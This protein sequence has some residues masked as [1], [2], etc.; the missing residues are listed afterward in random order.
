[1]QQAQTKVIPFSHSKWKKELRQWLDPK[2]KKKGMLLPQGLEFNHLDPK[3]MSTPPNFVGIDTETFAENGNM[4]CLSNSKNNDTLYGSVDKLP[5][6]FDV[7]RYLKRLKT[8]K[9]TYFVA[10][11]LKFDASV[12]LKCMDKSILTK[13][14]YGIEDEKY[15]I[16]INDLTITY[17]HKKCL[18]FQ[19]KTNVVKIYDAMQFFMGAG[20]GGKSSLDAVAKVYL[21]EQKQ[22][23]GKY[24]DKKFPSK[25]T[26]KELEEIVEYCQLDCT[27]TEKLM[28]IWVDAF[29]KNF[30]FYP[31]AFYSAGYLTSQLFKTKLKSFPSFRKIPFPVQSLAYECYFGGRFEIMERG[32]LSNI[33][34]YDINSAYPYAMTLLPDFDNGKW[35]KITSMEKFQKY[36]KY[37]GFYRIQVKSNERNVS[38]FLFRGFNGQ[39]YAPRG[40]FI[41]FTTSFEIV[42]S[43]NYDVEIKEIIGYAFIPK[44]KVKTKFNRLIESMYEARL[45]Q[46]NPGQK[47]VYKVL[48]NSGYGKFAQNKPAPKNLFNP[49]YCAAITGKCRS[50]LLDAAKD[51]KEDIVMFATDGVFSKKKLKLP[52][53]KKKVL[54]AWDYEFHPDMLLVMAG[55]YSVNNK[56]NKKLKTKSRGFSLRHFDP[57]T[58]KEMHFDLGDYKLMLDNGKYFYEIYNM[59][60]VAISQAV[61]QHKYSKDD[62]GKM[63]YVRKEIDLNGDH[64]R[65]WN[66]ELVDVYGHNTS[67]T[68]II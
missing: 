6:I 11:N 63:E 16:K 50:M 14:Y 67:S 9:N 64:K 65:I 44:S 39:V 26:K 46:K 37:V 2:W 15:Q 7:F 17:L 47:Y 30:N 59:K 4:I 19:Y 18:T 62:I 28:D 22:Y 27:L 25:L 10:W 55:I 58:N 20:E 51:N 12:L 66:D 8:T 35:I 1:M 42:S 60:P 21:G 56:E 41:T 33:H 54:G 36:K 43:E 49:V 53:P 57:S 45:K 48:V 5:T 24:Q 38:P 32:K 34:H 29:Y 3:S 52:T 23:K 13:F 31:N 40:E 61:I 68:L